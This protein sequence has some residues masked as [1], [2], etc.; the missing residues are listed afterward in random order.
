MQS[1]LECYEAIA[2]GS[3]A[4]QGFIEAIG[5]QA[6]GVNEQDLG[7]LPIEQLIAHGFEDRQ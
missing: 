7:D 4:A 2:S 3:Q 5:V 6:V 1:L